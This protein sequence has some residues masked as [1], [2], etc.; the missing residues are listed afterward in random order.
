MD[1]VDK[2]LTASFPQG[3]REKPFIPQAKGGRLLKH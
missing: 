1:K 2:T 3:D